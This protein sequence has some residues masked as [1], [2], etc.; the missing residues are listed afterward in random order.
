MSNKSGI[1]VIKKVGRPRGPEKR[2]WA[3]RLTEEQRVLVEGVLSGFVGQEPCQKK[4][5]EFLT[6]PC[7]E[8][9]PVF[10]TKPEGEIWT[11][12]ELK[13]QLQACVEGQAAAEAKA[14]DLQARLDRC[15]RATDDEKC[16]R[17][18]QLY[19]ELKSSLGKDKEG[20]NQL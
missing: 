4:D 2:F 17:W 19:D 9:Q 7:Q 15:S 13:A 12:Q 6:S 10:L 5:P 3:K 20:I 1:D 11:Y 18:I 8:N 16:R 14:A